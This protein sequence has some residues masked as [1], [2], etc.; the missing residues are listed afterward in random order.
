MGETS[1][2]L[3]RLGLFKNNSG[4]KS[5]RHMLCF[6][7][8]GQ[9][10]LSWPAVSKRGK[11]KLNALFQVRTQAIH[12][13]MYVPWGFIPAGNEILGFVPSSPHGL[14]ENS[15]PAQEQ[16]QL[17]FIAEMRKCQGN[18]YL[19]CIQNTFFSCGFRLKLHNMRASSSLGLVCL[20]ENCV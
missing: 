20:T 5:V 7:V 18:C 12:T 1:R 3:L 6:P 17:Q 13:Q 19:L 2:G 11:N 9:C 16:I 15:S 14:S 4:A 8:S 10:K